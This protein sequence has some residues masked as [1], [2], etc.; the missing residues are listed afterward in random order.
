M[1]FYHIWILNFQVQPYPTEESL[2]KDMQIQ[3]NWDAYKFITVHTDP[4]LIKS[5]KKLNNLKF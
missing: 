1:I 2:E 3:A 4:N 5:N